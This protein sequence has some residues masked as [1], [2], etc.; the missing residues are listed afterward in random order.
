M[1]YKDYYKILGVPK[2]A[3]A[4]DIKKAYRKLAKQYH[5]DKNPGDKAAEA[6]FKEISEANEVLSDP[7]KRKYYDQLG[8]DWA[9]YSQYG[10]NPEDFMRGYTY[11]DGRSWQQQYRTQREGGFSFDDIFG[12]GGFSDFFKYFF[13]GNEY[14]SSR[15]ATATRGQDY[16]TEM[17]ISLED[18]ANG[19]TRILSVMDKKLRI[20]IKPGVADGQVLKLTGHGGESSVPGG[21]K[22]DLFVK[23]KIKPHKNIERKGNDLYY[24]LPV[25]SFAA[26]LGEKVTMHVLGTD[27]AF[28][29]PKGSDSGKVFRLK[30]KGMPVYDQPEQ[31]GDLYVTLQL[32]SPKNISEEDL[33]IIRRLAE[34]YK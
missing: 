25:N 18:A 3:T 33:A 13:G 27:I 34:K 26:M 16:E 20:K 30:G 29:I 21:P 23:I 1:E 12:E 2:N 22:G 8:A 28:S 19:A 7:E 15:R 9:K 32:Y 31:R 10:G 4:E 6:K 17:E 24:T 11:G 5:P 14:A